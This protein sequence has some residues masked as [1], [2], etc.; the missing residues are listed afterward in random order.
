MKI[1]H[2]KPEDLDTVYEIESI[3]FPETEAAKK[4]EIEDRL[5]LNP[6]YFWMCEENGA[7]SAFIH[8]YPTNESNLCD[9]MF[10][11]FK[12]YDESGAWLMLISVATLPSYRKKG[13]ASLVMDAVIDDSRKDGRK[14]IVLTCKEAL[15]PFYSK[16]G[17]SNEGVSASTHGGAVWYQMRL[18]F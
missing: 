7:V 16:F 13:C 4:S 6:D 14:G 15:I 18:I 17:F 9:D 1:I 2:A 11:N 12:Y 10:H 8:G 3:S 5:K